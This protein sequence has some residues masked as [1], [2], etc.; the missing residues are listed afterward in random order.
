MRMRMLA[1]CCRHWK[2]TSD[3][4]VLPAAL[5][6]LA[7]GKGDVDGKRNGNVNRRSWFNDKTNYEIFRCSTPLAK[8]QIK[9]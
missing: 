5:Q 8:F 9:K 2:F 3:T 6:S 4:N 7:N 1:A